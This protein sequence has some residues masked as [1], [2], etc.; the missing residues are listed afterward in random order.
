MRLENPMGTIF[1]LG[2]GTWLIA[3][4][5]GLGLHCLAHADAAAR[6]LTLFDT[7]VSTLDTETK[8]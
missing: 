7:P 3:W 6:L 5:C 4:A 1:L 2:V 8:E